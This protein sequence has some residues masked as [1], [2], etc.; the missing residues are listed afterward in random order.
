MQHD[1]CLA[2]RQSLKLLAWSLGGEERAVSIAG[3]GGGQRV[4]R[5]KGQGCGWD[6]TGRKLQ[7]GVKEEH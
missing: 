1:A 2:E 7:D 5:S 3:S 4:W 6:G